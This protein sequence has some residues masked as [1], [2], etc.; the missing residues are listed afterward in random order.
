M[1]SYHVHFNNK[2]T[3]LDKLKMIYSLPE[4]CKEYAK[5]R[6]FQDQEIPPEAPKPPM[7]ASNTITLSKE[8]MKILS[9][10][11]KFALRNILCKKSY[12]AEYEKGLIKEKYGRIGKDEVKGE[13]LEESLKQMERRKNKNLLNGWKGNLN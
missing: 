8:E 3:Q 9:K 12:M 5:L 6:V 2:K 4:E 11:P 7:V 1:C 13:V 10:C